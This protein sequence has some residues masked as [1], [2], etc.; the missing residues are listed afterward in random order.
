MTDSQDTDTDSHQDFNAFAKVTFLHINTAKLVQINLA[1]G[2][3]WKHRACC[4]N[5]IRWRPGLPS[6]SSL[7]LLLKAAFFLRILFCLFLD[8][9]V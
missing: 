1:L 4:R 9:M 8:V 2:T 5:Q 7:V 3:P 6:F